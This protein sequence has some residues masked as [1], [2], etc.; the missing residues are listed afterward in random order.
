METAR[1]R[2]RLSLFLFQPQVGDLE[3]VVRTRMREQTV[4]DWPVLSRQSPSNCSKLGGSSDKYGMRC[5][6]RLDA[7]HTSRVPYLRC[8][9]EI[10]CPY[11]I[12]AK[13]PVVLRTYP[14]HMSRNLLK[15]NW[16]ISINNLS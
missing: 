3:D 1:A 12:M 8:L 4:A 13:S 5:I 2:I 15:D 14:V 9:G 11:A 10:G 6:T 16:S 7:L